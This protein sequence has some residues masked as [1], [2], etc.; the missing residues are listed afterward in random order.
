MKNIS[1]RGSELPRQTIAELI[2]IAAE[3]KGII[4]LGPGEPDFTT[5]RHVIS[6]AKNRLEQGYTH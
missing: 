6:L 1:E 2:K 5:P 4:S 3:G